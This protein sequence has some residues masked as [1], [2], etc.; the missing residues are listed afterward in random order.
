MKDFFL[1]E[2]GNFTGLEIDTDST[3]KRNTAA[4]GKTLAGV[5]NPR[6]LCRCRVNLAYRFI[7]AFPCCQLPV[8]FFRK[9]SSQYSVAIF[10]TFFSNCGTACKN[11]IELFRN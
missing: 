8:V 5:L 11:L 10:N 3:G 4:V 9:M 2:K 1:D 7:Y 6:Q